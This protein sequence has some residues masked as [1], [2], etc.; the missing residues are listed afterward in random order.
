ML[1]ARTAGE[2]ILG[3]HSR[4][5]RPSEVWVTDLTYIPTDEGWR[6]L[7]GIK[8]RY[9]CEI[10]GYALGERMTA[11]LVGQALFQATRARRPAHGLIHHSDRGSLR[12]SR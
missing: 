12:A 10:V 9:T 7:A 6:Y 5:S 11:D 1:S 8:E 2:N 4:P 3:G